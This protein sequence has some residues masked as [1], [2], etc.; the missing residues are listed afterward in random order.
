MASISRMSDSQPFL[1]KHW[2]QRST[3][4]LLCIVL[5]VSR[6]SF[7]ILAKQAVVFRGLEPNTSVMYIRCE[8]RQRLSRKQKETPSPP[9]PTPPHVR[10]HHK[11]HVCN[12]HNHLR[13]IFRCPHYMCNHPSHHVCNHHDHLTLPCYLKSQHRIYIQRFLSGHG[14][15]LNGSWA[16]HT[17]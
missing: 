13:I 10:H 8:T 16:I 12:R 4:M 6:C 7:R 5:K 11:H 2:F 9:P 1:S 17:A 14:C 15:S 3:A